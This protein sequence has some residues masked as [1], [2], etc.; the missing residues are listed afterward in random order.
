MTQSWATVALLVG[1]T[2]I[3]IV[4]DVRY[5][6]IPNWVTLP[7]LSAGLLI[8]AIERGGSGLAWSAIGATIGFFL[9]LAPWHVDWVG[10][11]DLKLLTAIGAIAGP[12]VAGLGF[13]AGTAIAGVMA[14]RR[15]AV[16]G[17]QPNFD[18]RRLPYGAALAAAALA[19]TAAIAS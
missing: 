12:I 6:R 8:A 13:A 19:V 3:A 1:L 10:A 5:R 9:L 4:W 7:A 15:R 17:A 2:A 16:P 11:G 18:Q 14:I